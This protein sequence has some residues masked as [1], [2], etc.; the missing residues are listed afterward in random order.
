MSAS[1]ISIPSLSMVRMPLVE[2]RSLTKRFS[3]S[4]QKR[5][6]CKLGENRRRVLLFA[7]ETLL[8]VTGFLPVTIQTLDICIASSC[9]RL[10]YRRYLSQPLTRMGLRGSKR[11]TLYQNTL[12]VSRHIEAPMPKRSIQRVTFS[13]KHSRIVHKFRLFT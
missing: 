11:A 13:D 5:W 9:W 12:L 10:V 4:T 2:T 8:P 7:C 6:V 1:T 3:D